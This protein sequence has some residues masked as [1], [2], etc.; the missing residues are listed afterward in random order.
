MG[1]SQPNRLLIAFNK[2]MTNPKGVRI[3]NSRFNIANYTKGL[4][5]YKLDRSY[6]SPTTVEIDPMQLY[7]GKKSV[8]SLPINTATR[9]TPLVKYTSSKKA[10]PIRNK[11][12]EIE[13]ITN[14]GVKKMVKKHEGGLI[15]MMRGGGS[16]GFRGKE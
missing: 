9:Q 8:L 5:E 11:N 12:G 6:K 13:V 16:G 1:Y 3:G 2:S 4:R 14:T 15:P 7:L 10:I